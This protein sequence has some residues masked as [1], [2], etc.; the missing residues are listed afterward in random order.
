VRDGQASVDLVIEKRGT[1]IVAV[2]ARNIEA[3]SREWAAEF[4]TN[5]LEYGD[6]PRCPYFL[7]AFRNRLYLWRDP[8]L[9]V[10][11]PDFEGDTADALQPHLVRL[12]RPLA[13]LSLSSFQMLIE[14]WLFEVVMGIL[15]DTGDRK[16]LVDSG[17]ADAVRDAYLRPK[18]A[19]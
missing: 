10:S 11:L 1:P 14:A 17:F 9:P 8:A 6:V 7:L 2:E 3:P 18:I 4:L 16:W 19:A 15:P 13:G 12:R 5:I